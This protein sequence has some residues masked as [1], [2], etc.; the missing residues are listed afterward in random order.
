MSEWP[1][2][3]LS[4]TFESHPPFKTPTEGSDWE[5]WK[6]GFWMTEGPVDVFE[7]P[8]YWW[9]AKDNNAP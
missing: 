9:Q 8:F 2:A 1:K 6:T 3:A 5:M 7:N 4:K